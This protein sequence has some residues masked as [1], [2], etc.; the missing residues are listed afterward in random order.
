[1]FHTA[2][3]DYNYTGG[4]PEQPD[5]TGL[6]GKKVAIVGTGATA[7][8]AVPELAKYADELTIFQRTPSAIDERGNRDTDPEWFQ[9]KVARHPGWFRERN[10][11]FAAF[12]TNPG[13]RPAEDMVDDGWTHMPSYSALV[14][15]RKPV[16][17]ENVQEHVGA[18]H[19]YDYPRQERVRQRTKGIVDDS[20]TAEALQAWYPSWCKRPCF[21]DEYLQAFNLENVKLV[22]TEGKSIDRIV[23]IG[24]EVAGKTYDVGALI[25]PILQNVSL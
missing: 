25:Q 7:V 2:R 19:T 16:T 21:H 18:L 5:L 17:M 10:L 4:T 12:L 23:E 11:N 14:G 13:T 3:W 9:T 22:D 20:A 8:Q 6:R 15:T 1:M 24:I